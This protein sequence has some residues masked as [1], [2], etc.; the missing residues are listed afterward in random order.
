MLCGGSPWVRGHYGD[1]FAEAHGKELVV[2][3]RLATPL[4]SAGVGCA[5]TRNALALLALHRAGQP[6]RAD[7]LTAD[8]ELGLLIGTYGTRRR[9]PAAVAAG[10]GPVVS[11]GVLRS[12]GRR[13]GDG[14]IYRGG[15]RGCRMT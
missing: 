1:E 14:G 13:V 15:Y 7:R 6:F 11:R 9:F 4:P 8:S 12:E 5:L 2:R 3:S 10:G